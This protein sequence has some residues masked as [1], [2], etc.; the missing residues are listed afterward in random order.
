LPTYD[1][2]PSSDEDDLLLDV[3]VSEGVGKCGDKGQGDG[4]DEGE[5]IVM[6]AMGL[7]VPPVAQP[8]GPAVNSAGGGS[9]A[10]DVDDAVQGLGNIDCDSEPQVLSEM[11]RD[12]NALSNHGCPRKPQFHGEGFMPYIF[13]E[14]DNVA[15]LLQA[16]LDN[17]YPIISV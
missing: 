11:Q 10:M 7:T 14:S 9:E 6:E 16:W 12:I 2:V 8:V 3:D 4:T 17:R 13:R 1:Y 5:E 15:R